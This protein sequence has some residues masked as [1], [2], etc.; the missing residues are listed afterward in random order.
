M[1]VHFGTRVLGLDHRPLVVAELSGNHNGSLERALALV[2][3]AAAAGAHAV[4][5]Q[6]YTAE[7]MTLDVDRPEFAIA[8]PN[9]LW[10]G[11][12]LHD[13]YAEASLPWEW[14]API[15]ERCARAGLACF[16]TPFDETAVA[17]L[18]RFD[19]PAYKIASFEVTDLPLIACAARTGRPLVI[20]NG[21]ATVAEID[22]AVR[23]ARE[24]GCSQIVLLQCT[25]TYPATPENSNLATIPHMRALFGTEVGVSDHTLGIGAAVAAV[26]LGAVFVEK[27]F[28]LARSDGGVDATFSLEPDELRAL[29]VETERAWLARGEVRYGPTVAETRSLAFRRSLYV[30]ADMAAGDAFTA[31]NL[32]IVRPGFGLPPKFFE[33]LLGARVTADVAKG[34]PVSWD[35]VMR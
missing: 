30:G 13:L 8:D 21:M 6:T 12:R 35:L 11:R 14:H 26:A 25:S 23:T 22:E 27:H 17:F 20:S 7:T 19:P 1:S 2:D 10:N 9:S 28:T 16:S 3:A 18:E 4:K 29:V 5:L 24:N 34:T 31:D 32:R 33:M 15:F